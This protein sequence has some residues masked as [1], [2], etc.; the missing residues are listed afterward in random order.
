M[1]RITTEGEMG[2]QPTSLRNTIKGMLTVGGMWLWTAAPGARSGADASFWE[3]LSGM[4]PS[5]LR[6]SFVLGAHAHSLT[7]PHW[8]GPGL[9]QWFSADSDVKLDR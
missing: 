8:I 4:T 5:F 3:D 1:I 2:F 6:T 7:P 9:W